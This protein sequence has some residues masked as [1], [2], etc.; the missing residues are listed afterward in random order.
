VAAIG[1]H[2]SSHLTLFQYLIPTFL[3]DFWLFRHL[4][5]ISK[6]N[7]KKK[8]LGLETH[9]LRL[10]CLILI[11]FVCK[12]EQSRLLTPAEISRFKR[13]KE[14]ATPLF[15]YFTVYNIDERKRCHL[16]L[17]THTLRRYALF[18]VR[19]HKSVYI[20]SRC[21]SSQS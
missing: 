10:H 7:R 5:L 13:N 11:R 14:I 12:Q 1:L 4:T 9:D 8:N 21:N 15:P 16:K 19:M 20:A 6:F 2:I 3:F 18:T 17:L